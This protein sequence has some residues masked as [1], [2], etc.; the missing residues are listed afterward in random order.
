M[1]HDLIHHSLHSMRT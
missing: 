1:Q